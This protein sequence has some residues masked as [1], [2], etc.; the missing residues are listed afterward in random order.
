MTV[1]F[2][3]E[4][5]EASSGKGAGD[6]NFPVGSFLIA[7]PLRPHVRAYYDF[8]RAADDI[9]DAPHL[10]ADEKVRRLDAFRRVLEGDAEGLTRPAELRRALL[11]AGIPLARGTDLLSAFSQD[12]VKSRYRSLLELLDYCRRSANPVGQFLLDLHGEDRA[13]FSA[14]DALCTSLQILNHLQ[15]ARDDLAALDRCYLPMD[16]LAEEGAEVGHLSADR[17]SPGLRRVMD[18]LL[19]V[20]ADL[21]SEAERLVTGLKSRRLAAES[22]VILRLAK[23]LQK[24]LLAGDPVA[25]RVALTK[26]DFLSAGAGGVFATAFS[27]RRAA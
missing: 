16:W 12:A 1:V 5:I 14:S 18:R 7:A 11:E 8:A 4:E 26:A 13:L 21:N 15:D 17:A 10:S 23:R 22:A 25:G 2:R 6:E 3:D 20:C 19:G 27:G 9:G 24:K